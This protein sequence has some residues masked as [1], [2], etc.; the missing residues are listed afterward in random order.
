MYFDYIIFLPP[1]SSKILF[2]PSTQQSKIKTKYTQVYT[3]THHDKQ[4]S[5]EEIVL[6]LRSLTYRPWYPQ[7]SLNSRGRL[8]LSSEFEASLG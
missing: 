5:M 7:G 4:T 8:W 2:P 3:H 1:N 6:L